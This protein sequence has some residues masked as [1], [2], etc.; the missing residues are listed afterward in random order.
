VLHGPYFDKNFQILDKMFLKS[1][2]SLMSASVTKSVF[3]QFTASPLYLCL[4]Y[5]MLGILEGKT[6]DQ[7][8][9]KLR[10]AFVPTFVTGLLWIPVSIVNFSIIPPGIPRMVTINVVGIFWQ[11]Y[12]SFENKKV[13]DRVSELSI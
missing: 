2:M 5:P 6:I 13:A 3:G 12:L 7:S 10:I 9:E 11:T 4:F 1:N 8:I